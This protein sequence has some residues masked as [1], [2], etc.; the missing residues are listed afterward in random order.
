MRAIFGDFTAPSFAIY[1]AVIIA[2]ICVLA[3]AIVRPS[4]KP[5][6]VNVLEA[7]TINPLIT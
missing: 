4:Q 3:I 2:I 6:H 1:I 5:R 7:A